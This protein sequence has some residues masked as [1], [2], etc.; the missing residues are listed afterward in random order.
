MG[1]SGSYPAATEFSKCTHERLVQNPERPGGILSHTVRVPRFEGNTE[2]IPLTTAADKLQAPQALLCCPQD[3]EERSGQGSRKA[4]V[5]I[6][7]RTPTRPESNPPTV[8]NCLSHLVSST[9]VL[10]LG[11]LKG[12]GPTEEKLRVPNDSEREGFNQGG[13]GLQAPP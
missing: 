3:F 6:R 13:E 12:F 5:P 9:R 1:R 10:D 7:E 2:A 4:Q 11:L 8:M